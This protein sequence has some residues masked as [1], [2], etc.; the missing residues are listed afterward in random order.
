LFVEN[1]N[2]G[3]QHPD[4]EEAFVNLLKAYS[5]IK[6]EEKP[7][8]IRKVMRS[9]SIR[10]TEKLSELLDLL[11]TEGLQKEPSFANNSKS[12]DRMGIVI[13]DSS[14]PVDCPHKLELERID[15]FYKEFL[16]AG[17][18]GQF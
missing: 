13:R 5:S 9:T 10:D 12:R 16:N 15:E 8:T 1:N 11:W 2:G 7:E 18:P 6:S 17:L 3:A 4:F 14:C